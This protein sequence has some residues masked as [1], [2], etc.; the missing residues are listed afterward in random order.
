MFQKTGGR[1]DSVLCNGS[2]WLVEVFP[3]G[4]DAPD[5]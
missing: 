5:L 1:S 3:K 2:F 4:K